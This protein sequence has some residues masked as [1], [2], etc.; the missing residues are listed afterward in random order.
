[1]DGRDIEHQGGVLD[2]VR[3]IAATPLIPGPSAHPFTILT[4]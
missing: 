4:L 2:A 3:L 1:L